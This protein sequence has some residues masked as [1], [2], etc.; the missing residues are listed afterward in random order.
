MEVEVLGEVANLDPSPVGLREEETDMNPGVA[1]LALE[2]DPS[3]A[4]S[5][6][7]GSGNGNGPRIGNARGVLGENK[8]SNL[9]KAA[10][11]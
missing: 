8:M 1:S 4:N 11:W 9:S 2:C 5:R 10:S 6:V 3:L 7:T